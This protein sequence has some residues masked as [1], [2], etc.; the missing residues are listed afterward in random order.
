VVT[1]PKCGESGRRRSAAKA[2]DA[3]VRRQRP[4]PQ[5]RRLG[6][7]PVKLAGHAPP[8][9]TAV[10]R[11]LHRHPRRSLSLWLVAALLFMQIAISAYACP[12]VMVMAAA[13]AT[14]DAATASSIAAGPARASTGAPSHGHHPHDAD[15]SAHDGEHQPVAHPPD[16]PA[17][18]PAATAMSPDMIDCDMAMGLGLDADAAQLCKLHCEPANQT[19]LHASAPVDA[20]MAPLLWAVLDWSSTARLA[21]QL[22]HTPRLGV[23]SGAPPPGA[24]PLYLSLL[25]LRN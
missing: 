23:A 10:H 8:R 22:G 6:V 21:Q 14:D 13:A 17:D 9:L 7:T 2:V 18:L 5:L 1:T 25:V 4:T 3:A 11:L 24:A 12:S 20:P 15:P 19:P 16:H